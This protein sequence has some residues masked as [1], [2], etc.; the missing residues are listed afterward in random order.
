MV[1]KIEMK[2]LTMLMTTWFK[3]SSLPTLNDPLNTL[4]ILVG[5]QSICYNF[6]NKNDC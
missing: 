2:Q 3:N 1:I 4:K 6:H 5:S